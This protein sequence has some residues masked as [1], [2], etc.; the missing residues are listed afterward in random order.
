MCQK[1]GNN[2]SAANKQLKR[3]KNG[4]QFRKYKRKEKNQPKGEDYKSQT[5]SGRV[6]III[7]TNILS[8]PNK[9]NS[10]LKETETKKK[11]HEPV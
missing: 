11:Q 2:S 5:C 9:I 8:N 7:Y 4:I 1:T 6:N 3:K 10:E